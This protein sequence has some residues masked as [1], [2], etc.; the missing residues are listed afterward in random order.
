[1]RP[2]SEFLSRMPVYSV[3]QSTIGILFVAESSLHYLVISLVGVVLLVVSVEALHTE[4]VPT[5]LGDT[6]GNLIRG[7]LLAALLTFRSI[8]HID[9]GSA[10]RHGIQEIGESDSIRNRLQFLEDLGRLENGMPQFD[11]RVNLIEPLI[12]ALVQGKVVQL[13]ARVAVDVVGH[14]ILHVF[15]GSPYPTPRAGARQAEF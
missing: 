4:H 10:L 12:I 6:L 13:F 3:R 9:T 11:L 5:V 2:A 14:C 1:N 15:V 8:I 7:K